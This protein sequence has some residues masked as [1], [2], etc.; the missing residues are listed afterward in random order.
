MQQFII[1]QTNGA[2]DPAQAGA[3]TERQVAL[4]TFSQAQRIQL[5][6]CPEHVPQGR[7][8]KSIR[9]VLTQS[10]VDSCKA[11]DRAEIDGQLALVVE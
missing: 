3:K 10:L 2:F 8:P 5:Q 9:V 4:S 1:R 6:D 11:G 7:V